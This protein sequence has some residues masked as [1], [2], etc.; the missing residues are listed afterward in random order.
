METGRWGT[1][2]AL[3]ILLVIFQVFSNSVSNQCLGGE[4]HPTLGF[5]ISTELSNVLLGHH[6]D[7]TRSEPGGISAL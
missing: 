4:T 5:G 1:K 7:F 6:F 3:R 2:S